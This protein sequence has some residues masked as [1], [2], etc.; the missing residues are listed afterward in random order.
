MSLIGKEV[1][2]K[3]FELIMSRTT[4]VSPRGKVVWESSDGTE[5]QVEFGFIN[6]VTMEPVRV[7]FPVTQLQLVT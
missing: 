6:P 3:R 1:R 5:A 7:V 4:H 2:P